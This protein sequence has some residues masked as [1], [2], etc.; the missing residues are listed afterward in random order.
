MVYKKDPELRAGLRNEATLDRIIQLI[1][2]AWEELDSRTLDA[3]I[4]SVPRRLIAVY[5]SKGWYIKY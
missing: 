4:D 3:L 5:A 1:V 2:E